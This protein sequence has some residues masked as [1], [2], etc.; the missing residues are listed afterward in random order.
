MIRHSRKSTLCERAEIGWCNILLVINMG[1]WESRSAESR[2]HT[3]CCTGKAVNP[4]SPAQCREL[5]ARMRTERPQGR[6]RQR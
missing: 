2:N 1:Q 6:G 5:P 4:F 3:H